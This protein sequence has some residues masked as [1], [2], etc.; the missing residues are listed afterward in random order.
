M[1]ESA[2]RLAA[3]IIVVTAVGTSHPPTAKQGSSGTNKSIH[4]QGVSMDA[5]VEGAW[6]TATAVV[7]TNNVTGVSSH[8]LGGLG[9]EDANHQLYGGLWSQMVFGDSFEEPA[10]PGGVSG[11]DPW[12]VPAYPGRPHRA[13]ATCPLAAH[14]MSGLPVSLAVRLPLALEPQWCARN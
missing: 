11:S 13:P 3:T 2:L 8:S 7:V 4:K 1:A 10:G 6:V 12:L 14:R 9:I 5:A